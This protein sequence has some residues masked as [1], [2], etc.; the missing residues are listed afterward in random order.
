MR[1][2]RR[3][4]LVDV[5]QRAD[6]A[7]DGDRLAFGREVS[8]HTF[9]RG[10]DAAGEVDVVVLQQDH[11]EQP[12]AVVLA[13]ADLHGH[14]VQHAHAG[15]GLARVEDLGTKSLQPLDVNGGLGRHAAHALHDVQQDALGLKQRAQASRDVKGHV[16][17]RDTVAVVQDLFEFHFGIE[18]LQYELRD[19]DPGDRALLLAQQAHASVFVGG[20]ARER[21]VVAVADVL[22]DAEFDQFIYER[23]VFGFHGSWIFIL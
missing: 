14:L 4:H 9:D 8:A 19:F 15:R 23:F 7:L 18:A 6:L 1:S 17:G 2:T 21:R 11:V 22:P 3:E 12:H 10:A 5:F 16:A 13:A 20:D